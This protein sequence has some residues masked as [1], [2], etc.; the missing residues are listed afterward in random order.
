MKCPS[1]TFAGFT[2]AT[3]VHA[4]SLYIHAQRSPP[5]TV[6]ARRSSL[7]WALNR[8]FTLKTRPQAPHP[9]SAHV[10]PNTRL[11]LHRSLYT[12]RVHEVGRM[13]GVGLG[14]GLVTARVGTDTWGARR[15]KL[16]QVRAVAAD[17]SDK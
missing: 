10:D 6:P 7:P 4:T 2:T 15:Y 13:Q 5:G 1:V 11:A 12:S 17:K 14:L 9:D 8:D 16:A 3:R